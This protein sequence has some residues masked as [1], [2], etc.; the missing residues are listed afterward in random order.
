MTLHPCLLYYHL[1]Q[2]TMSNRM[3]GKTKNLMIPNQQKNQE[4]KSKS[5]TKLDTKPKDKLDA[6]PKEKTNKKKDSQVS[7]PKKPNNRGRRRSLQ[8]TSPT[9]LFG[10]EAKF[11][12]IEAAIDPVYRLDSHVTSAVSRRQSVDQRPLEHGYERY[13][14]WI[15]RS[16]R[17]FD[18][19]TVVGMDNAVVDIVSIVTI[20]QDRN[21]GI[22]DDVETFSMDTGHGRLTSCIQVKLHSF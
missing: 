6:K 3:L 13:I 20:L 15:D 11:I 1:K 8:Q 16:L 7:H 4:P 19:V 10:Q 14:D 21:I 18:T 9:D 5:D 17:V 22:H 2:Q 12:T